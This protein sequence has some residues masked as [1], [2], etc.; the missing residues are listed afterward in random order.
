M[1]RQSRVPI[2]APPAF[3]AGRCLERLLG[4]ILT[5]GVAASTLLGTRP[6][7]AQTGSMRVSMP[8]PT[9]ASLGKFGDLPVSLYTGVPEIGIPLFTARGR[10]LELPIALRY[11]AA[12]VRVQEIG[13]WAG[14]GWTLEAGGAITRTVR[15]LVDESMNGYYNTGDTFWNS[16][17]WPTP[18]STIIDRIANE[19]L[20]GEPDR[21]FFSFAGRSGQFVMGPTSA[22]TTIKDY[23]TVPYQKL[24]IQPTFGGNGITSWTITTEEGT[25][26]TFA[27]AE[28]T[29]DYN[30]TS[31]GDQIPAHYGESH[32]SAWHL[33]EIRSAGG[34][35][36]TL[37]YSSYGARHRLATFREKFDQVVSSGSSCVP[38]QFD[39]VNEYEVV[40]QRL[41]SIRTAAH[42]IKFSAGATLR[43]DA[44]SPTGAQQEPRLDRITVT[45]PTGAVL[46]V[47][48]LEHDYSTGRLTLKNVYEQDRNGVS[49][50][51]YSLTYGG[52]ALP[53]LSSYALDHWG[54]YNGKTS[55]STS[56]PA[57]IAPG[58][59]ILSGADRTPDQ[60]YMKAGTLTR[61]TYP[62]GGYNEFLYEPND[63][64]AIGQSGATPKDHGQQKSAIARSDAYEGPQST[65]FTVGGLER[66]KATVDVF[67]DPACGTLVGCPYAEL[68]GVQTWTSPGVYEVSLAPGTY[69]ATASEEGTGGFAR[70]TITW[71]EVDYVKRKTGGALR[72]S[73][74]RTAD[75]SGNVTVRKYRYRLQSDTA[76]SSGVVNLEVD[77]DY[78]YSSPDCSYFSRSSMSKM[79]LGEGPP[80]GY[81]EVTVWHG[82]NGE[83]GK[84]R[85]AFRSVL[86]GQDDPPPNSAWPFSTRTSRE[87][88]RGQQ[89]GT[90]EYNASG[91]IQRL[92]SSTY[93][94]RDEN[95]PDTTTTRRLRGMSI[96]SFSAGKVGTTYVYNAFEVIS[97]WA[98]QQSDTTVV[99]DDAGSS[100]FSTARTYSYGNP[101]HVQLTER[102]ETN[103]DGTQ[104]VTRMKYPADYATGTGN[105]E[106]AAL[107][108]MQGAAHQH[109]PLIERSVVKRVGTTET[110]EEAA[111]TSFKEYAAGQYLPYQRFALN[112]ASG[113][114]DFAPSSITSGVFTKDGRYL[115]EETANGYDSGGR[116][117]Q[118][119][120]ARGKL[121]NFAYGG[122]TNAA[123]L[124]RV[125]RLRDAA[126]LIDLVTEVGYDAD[127]L[128]SSIKDE[129]GTF[130][131]FTYDLHGRL[132]QVRNHDGV[133][134][135]AYGYSYSRTSPGWTFNSANPNAVADTVFLQQTPTPKSVVTTA[136]V[137]GLGRPIQSVVQDG[138]EYVVT[139]TQYDT[140]GRSWRSWKPYR[141]TVAGYDAN[142]AANAT[143]FHNSY[144]G[145]TDAKPFA[146]TQYTADAL[147]RVKEERPEYIGISPT[148]FTRYAYGVDAAVKQQFT[149]VRDESGRKTRRFAD[150]FGNEV[151]IVLGFG[152][153]E[154]T[155]TTLGYDI[156]GRQTQA[157]DPRSLG[158]S[159][160]QNTRGLL[161][162]KSSPDAGAVRYKYD[163]AGNARFTQDANQAGQGQVQFT[164]YDFASRPLVS[165]VG[166]AAF[167][168]L[169]PDASSPPALETTQ[170]NW[171]VVRQY[172]AKPATT[173][174]P[175]NL[176]STEIAPLALANVVGRLAAVA[177]RSNGAWQ[178]ALFSYDAD[179]QVATRYTY[180]QANGGAS[181]L[182][183]LNTTVGYTRDLRDALTERRL[184]VGANT[185]NHWYDYDARG[186]LWKVFASSGSTKPA[187]A[188]VTYR[189]RPGGQVQDRQFQGGPL[190]P[191]RYTI[192]EQLERIGDPAGTTYPFSARYAYHPNGAVSEAEFYSAGSPAAQKRYRYAFPAY[193]ALNRLKSADF[194]SWSGSAWTATAAYD[195][196]GI[197]YDGS[198]NLTA[199]QR[200]R[201][202]GTLIDNLAYAYPSSSNRLSSV[203]DAVG[204]TPESWD[205][206]SGSFTYDANG[207]LLTAPAPYAITAVTYDHRNLPLSLTSNGTTTAY[208]YDE[209]GQRIAKQVGGGNTEVYLL[210]GA[211]TLG[212]FTVDGAGTATSWYLNVLGGDKV[213]GRQPNAGSRSYYHGDLLGSTRAV[214]QG[215]TVVETYDYEPWGLLMPGRTLGGGTRE[216]FTGKER[217]AESGMDYFGARLY[218][219]ALVRWTAVDPL[220]EKHPEWSPYNY[221]L[222]NPLTLI[223]PDGRQISAQWAQQFGSGVASGAW[224]GLTGTVSGVVN[225]VLHPIQTAMGLAELATP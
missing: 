15:G 85:H 151:K 71:Q 198:G 170:D 156:L 188:D 169:D 84:S 47:F 49:L 123:F 220:S 10:T 192:R 39:A 106:A 206:E 33:T 135:K 98:Y 59:A 224:S 16:G 37:H 25:R 76:K 53:A 67:L 56:V 54:Y 221:V 190:V 73:E 99:Y 139:A 21:F 195:L 50:P 185:F 129:G 138:T 204:V 117:T 12:G 141:R 121:T 128:V 162:A 34:D 9:A 65:T 42:T 136:Y 222:D 105:P 109:S 174:F 196:A 78:S 94:F 132:R 173:A 202:S 164:T 100:S 146:E 144:H 199:L 133:V 20:D 216:G 61:I 55:N 175:W 191:V 97:A 125:T 153:A 137:D 115:L 40:V 41:D 5:I 134:V 28:T 75:A 60:G 172:D 90:T 7:A 189:Y 93:S 183:V 194:S 207:N 81:S 24:Q 159:Y 111:L 116:I 48:Q 79:P 163:V 23:R 219:P 46:R 200:Y 32:T 142:F 155:T 157:T 218:M 62:T 182:T 179:G 152:A 124:T 154:A 160:T 91:Q 167:G 168:T 193:D 184:T 114:A 186:L 74:L 223:D 140:M 66:I 44:L 112:A 171:L 14:I 8:S 63:Y 69:V 122:N 177:S 36:V 107:T 2:G 225:T 89:L 57:A 101:A 213:I 178:V 148:A 52:P 150:T 77:Y 201:E 212:V 119:A 96:N 18:S 31:P 13:G 214:V 197:G 217:D 108:A 118:L 68:S 17:N 27:A 209:G 6:V 22:S 161:T 88:K 215:T 211:S 147:A 176:F 83:Y 58:G 11:H 92:A 120:D 165:G 180:T 126:G 30:T 130:R 187:A 82:A 87:W 43:T 104:R 110:V 205:A 70:I 38:S 29:T 86:N 35:L 1:S 3:R 149:E 145:A 72:V 103:S 181:V 210:E 95:T 4:M 143:S 131:Y 26:Y 203:S 127:G 64:G 45:T 51:P 102:T 166:A 208:R 158:T 80:V 113:I 19:T